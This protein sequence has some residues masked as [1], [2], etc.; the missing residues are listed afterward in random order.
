MSTLDGSIG[1]DGLPE[2]PLPPD[3]RDILVA[4]AAHELREP[5]QA[6]LSFLNVVLQGKVGE[7][8]ET[9]TDF[10]STADHAMRRLKRRVEDLHLILAGERGFTMQMEAVDVVQHLKECCLEMQEIAASFQIRIQTDIEAPNAA[11]I[12]IDPARLDQILL[13][14]IENAVQYSAVDSVVRVFLRESSSGA[15]CVVV[16]NVVDRP[17]SE[18]PKSWFTAFSRGSN[19]KSVERR[20]QGLGLTAVEYLVRSQGGHIMARSIGNHIWFGVIFAHRIEREA[21]EL[22]DEDPSM[23]SETLK[24]PRIWST[25]PVCTE[26]Y[27]SHVSS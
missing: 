16:N 7:L 26:T 10:L 15:W 18:D 6:A 20:G 5:L 22:S 27:P 9:Q 25:G 14:L 3:N 12:D 24:N 4:V 17:P 21:T 8:N 19:A 11:W 2:G 1:Q 13:N 23:T